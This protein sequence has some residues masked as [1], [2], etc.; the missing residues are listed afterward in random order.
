[1]EYYTNS[2]H[3]KEQDGAWWIGAEVF[4]NNTPDVTHYVYLCACA[5][6][7]EAQARLAKFK[8]S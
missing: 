3:I 6:L 8:G 7:A 4:E 5:T 1:M 2:L